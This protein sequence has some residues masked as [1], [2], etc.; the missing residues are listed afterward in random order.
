MWIPSQ[1]DLEGIVCIGDKGKKWERGSRREGREGKANW[2]EDLDF[3]SVLS[4]AEKPAFCTK[5]LTKC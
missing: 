1:P 2:R 4:F 3:Y 5:T